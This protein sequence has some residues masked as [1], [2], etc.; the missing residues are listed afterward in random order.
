MDNTVIAVV[1]ICALFMCAAGSALAVKLLKCK[2]RLYSVPAF[3]GLVFI[4]F[5]AF[6]LASVDT[7]VEM[8][9][10]NA[11]TDVYITDSL[12]GGYRYG[13]AIIADGNGRVEAFFPQI[14]R[15]LFGTLY[16]TARRTTAATVGATRA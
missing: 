6:S 4:A 5:F 3:L 9:I 12:N 16:H 2:K 11:P 8:E 14:T 7:L 10:T 1:I 15:L 13:P